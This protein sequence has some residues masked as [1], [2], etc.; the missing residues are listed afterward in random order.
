MSKQRLEGKVAIVTG[1]ATGIGQAIAIRFAREGAAVVIDYVGNPDTPA[2]TE[3]EIGS[4]GGKCIGVAADVRNTGLDRPAEPEFY[5]V[6]KYTGD[7][8]A[9]SGDDAWWRRATAWPSSSS[10]TICS[11]T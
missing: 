10:N 3:K 4:F 5:R 11:R 2:A 7:E 1:A 6:R 8:I 9:G